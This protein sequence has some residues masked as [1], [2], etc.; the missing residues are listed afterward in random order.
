M[1]RVLLGCCILGLAVVAEEHEGDTSADPREMMR[2]WLLDLTDEAQA[3]RLETYE[4]LETPENVA[5]Y[6]ERL[7]AYFVEQ[8]GGWPERT[9]LNPQIVATETRDGCRVEKIIY[10]SR[11]QFYVTALLFLPLSEPPYPGVL[12]PCGHSQ[13]G[14][15]SEVYQRACIALAM[16]GI[17]ALIYD[18]VGQGERFQIL[19]ADGKPRIGGTQ[20]HTM[21][22][23]DCILLG[24][25]IAQFRIWDGMRGIDYLTSRPDIDATRIGC[26][27]NSGGGTLTSYIMALDDRVQVAA[28]SCYLT[29]LNRLVHTIGPQDAEQDIFGQM[30]FGMD[31]ADYVI[32]RAPKPTLMCSA[33][34]DFFDITGTWDSYRQAKRIYTRLGHAERVDLIET[35]AKHGFSQLLREAMVRWMRRWMLDLDAEWTEPAFDV[36]TD[37]EATVTPDGQVVLLDGARTITDFNIAHNARLAPRRLAF[38][39]DRDR[40]LEKVRQLIGTR[41]VAEISV[42][43]ITAQGIGGGDTMT[44]SALIG[45]EE[46]VDLRAKHWTQQPSKGTYLYLHGEGKE[47]YAEAVEARIGEGYD[48]LAVDLRGIGETQSLRAEGSWGENFGGDWQDVMLAYL[49]GRSYVGM[50]VEDIIACAKFVTDNGPVHLVAQGEAA[51]PALH[52]AALAPDLFASVRIEE[53]IESWSN[54]VTEPMTKNQLVN[55]VH[56]A[57]Q[58]YDL[59]DLVRAIPREKLTIVNP[60]HPDGTAK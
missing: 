45:V 20:E 13:N 32:L 34:E 42:L 53:C 46:G 51:V 7:R 49:L 3:A 54:V 35:D 30:A 38:W 21:V 24:T 6:Q 59:P 27:G 43:G 48:A 60:V 36:L 4:A 26:T 19:D 29:S 16:N 10:E 14:K 5:A 55:T 31:H 8:L 50:R 23:L 12:V 39:E 52:A 56:G 44:S 33:T 15:A 57:L 40:A 41:P 37:E 22:G 2:A 1:L 47:G 9:P 25:N 17:A 18:P 58:Y 28:P 11:P